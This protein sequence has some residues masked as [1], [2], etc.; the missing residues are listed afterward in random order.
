MRAVSGF[1]ILGLVL[2]LVIL[3]QR[4]FYEDEWV[5]LSTIHKPMAELVRWSNTQDIHPPG[6]YAMDRVI[7]Q[8]VNAPRVLGAVHL[9]M[10]WAGLLMFVMAARRLLASARGQTLFAAIAFLHPQV[11]MWNSSL[12]WYPIWWGFAFAMIAIGL[13]RKGAL[14]PGWRA[15]I[16]LGLAAGLLVY[17]DYL[18]L[19]FLPLFAAAWVVRWG[20]S[21]A[22]L[23]RLALIAALSAALATP[24]LIQLSSAILHS[25]HGQMT[26][27]LMAGARLVHA[28]TMGGAILPWHPVAVIASL[29]VLLPCTVLA[30]TGMPATVQRLAAS[31]PPAHRELIALLG[32]L[33]VM[34]VAGAVTG[35]GSH[36]YALMGLAPMV[37]FVLALGAERIR[38]RAVWTL[39]VV[40]T[41]LWMGTGAWHLT[42]RASTS[43]RLVNDHPEE[44]IARLEQL[45][46][47]G[48]ALVFTNDLVLTFEI[49]QRRARG[50]TRLAV[51]S[52]MEDRAHG[53]PSGLHDDPRR[54]PYVIVVTHPDPPYDE[55]GRISHEALVRARDFIDQS[56]TIDLGADPDWEWKRRIPGA[57]VE[58]ARLRAWY[59]RP[60]PGDWAAIGRR[61]QDAARI[62]ILSEDP[63]VH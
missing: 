25:G 40:V 29:V 8:A 55:V 18:A 51:C 26:S 43:K 50:T 60:L 16:A 9:L 30:I 7:L 19:L 46:N 11:L 14:P 58:S 31:Q 3:T 36:T 32:L 27:P 34:A 28:L 57:R 6:V 5:T 54:F 42:A 47:G 15:T 17:V 53:Y 1:A 12:R 24:Q 61:M 48:P 37:A 45:A 49:N 59:G 4:N 38:G 41:A 2:G 23:G 20:W 56:R 35:I 63:Q 44:N 33:I 22:A 13:L 39:V 10:W 21:R 52:C 62:S